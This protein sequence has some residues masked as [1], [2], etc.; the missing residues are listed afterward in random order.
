MDKLVV[1]NFSFSVGS[2]DRFKL[3]HKNQERISQILLSPNVPL[4]R[5]SGFCI[6]FY[7]PGVLIGHS[8]LLFHP[9]GM[10]GW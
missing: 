1:D 9:I 2:F 3:T 5:K 6:C 8:F 4:E 10:F 7:Q